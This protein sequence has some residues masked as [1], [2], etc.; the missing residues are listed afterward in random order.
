MILVLTDKFDVHADSVIQR[1]RDCGADCTRL[2]LDA[3]SLMITSITGRC[4][5]W[6]VNQGGITIDFSSVKAVWARR[7]TVSEALEQKLTTQSA[8]Y[9]IWKGEWNRHLFGIYASLR[10]LPWINPIANS[11][12]CDNKLYQ[13]EMASAAGFQIPDFICSNEHDVL[14]EFISHHGAAAVKFLSQDTYRDHSGRFVG[15][16]VNRLTVDDVEDFKE[17]HENP[18]IAQRYVEKKY[19]VRYTFVDGNGF[20]CLIDSQKSA[21]AN[22]DWRRYDLPST[23]HHSMDAP[24]HIHAKA[25][26][27]MQTLGLVYGA[28]D[29][30]VD[31]DDNWWYLEVNSAGQWLWIE[32]LTGLPIS[33]AVVDA[34]IRRSRGVL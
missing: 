6:R 19:E 24:D 34:L 30:V 9:S 27:L 4:S 29:F 31:T 2:N 20:C 23:P 32:D 11:A 18:I 12:L 7:L 26:N 1:L 10:S 17:T 14:R 22:I 5:T 33:A 8:G 16:Y 3:D 15:L 21:R 28:F 13:F 25:I